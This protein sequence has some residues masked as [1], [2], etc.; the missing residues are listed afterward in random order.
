MDEFADVPGG[1]MAHSTHVKGLGTYSGG[2]EQP[3]IKVT[4]ATGIPKERCAQINLGYLD[5]REVRAAEWIGRQNEGILLV[6]HAGEVLHRLKQ[7]MPQ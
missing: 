4:L 5:P 7:E 6:D 1:I 2:V 3:R